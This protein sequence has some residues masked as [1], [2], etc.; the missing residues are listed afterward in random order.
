MFLDAA[1]KEATPSTAFYGLNQRAAIRGA[2][3]AAF[4]VLAVLAY[5]HNV[6]WDEFYYLSQVHA[7]L[8]GRLDRPLQTIHVHFFGWLAW[9]PGDEMTQIFAGRL[10][11]M[12]CLG[13]TAGAIW[14]IA[15]NL[16]G[17]HGSRS[18]AAGV[19]VLAFLSSGY[20]LGHGASFRTDPIAAALLM[21]SLAVVMTG[22]ISSPQIVLVAALSALALLVTI[23]SALYFPAILGAMV[24]RAGER[25]MILRMLFAAVLAVGFAVALYLWHASG[26]VQVAGNDAAATTNNALKTT[27]LEAGLA[28][29]GS[30]ALLWALLS[31]AP[32]ALVA[33][34][35]VKSPSTR[36]RV[37]LILFALPLILSVLFYRNAF[38]YFFPFIVPPLMLAV[39]VGAARLGAMGRLNTFIALM[40]LSGGWQ[41]VTSFAEDARLQRDTIAE[42]HRLFPDPVAYIDQNAMISSFPREVFFMSSWGMSRYRAAGE[43][44]MAD[45]IDRTEPP[46]LLASRQNLYRAMTDPVVIDDP[47]LLMPEDIGVLRD[48][49]V[50]YSGAIWLAGRQVMLGDRPMTLSMPFPGR[51]RLQSPV[52]VDIDGDTIAD[53]QVIDAGERLTISGAAGTKVRLI[54]DTGVTPPPT[55]APWAE[56]YAGFWLLPF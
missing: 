23:K 46:L 32:L 21:V 1:A 9:L 53:G 5:T 40:M 44:V 19:A 8:D 49:Y 41:A 13:L 35:I 36:L 18:V 47:N 45:L 56:H 55:P 27:L 14:H 17:E 33:I 6:N 38:A 43:P 10:V 52:A 42:V 16:V 29:R 30:E 7:H 25:G 51:Y 20:A 48:T 26:I 50:H 3:I 37:V 12:L 22:P 34:G 15:R 39:A 54:W 24:W 28:P 4:C 2:L 31:F 11:M